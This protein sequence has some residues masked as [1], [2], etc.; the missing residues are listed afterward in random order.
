MKA[1]APDPELRYQSAQDFAAD[2]RAFRKGEA[3]A[4]S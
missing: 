3:L 4:I 1:L 2:L